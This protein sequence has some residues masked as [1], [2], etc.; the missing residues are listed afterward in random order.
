MSFKKSLFFSHSGAARAGVDN[1]TKSLSIEWA[2]NG[3]RVNAV[4]PVGFCFVQFERSFLYYSWN[5]VLPSYI[6]PARCFTFMC[7]K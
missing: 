5:N 1:L 2:Q 4:A 6:F 7:S 3:I